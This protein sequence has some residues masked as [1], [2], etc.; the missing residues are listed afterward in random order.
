MQKRVRALSEGALMCALVGILL[1][2]NRQFGGII[3]YSFY[4]IMTFPILVYTVKY[5][6]KHG[7]MVTFSS[8]LLSMFLSTPT[9]IFYLVSCSL[10]GLVYG[11]GIRKQWP[12]AFL[13]TIT[14][15]ITLLSYII[16][17]GLLAALF[18]YQMTEE[19]TFFLQLFEQLS[20]PIGNA[21][22]FGVFLWGTI[23][24]LTAFLQTICVHV[25][26]ILLL[27]RLR[28]YEY[29]M[30]S[31]YDFRLPKVL[32]YACFIIWI[33]FLFGNVVKLEG[34][35]FTYLLCLWILVNIISIGYGVTTCFLWLMLHGKRRWSIVVVIGVFLPF[36]Q[37]LIAG[38]GMLDMCLD[39]RGKWKRGVL[40]GAF[41]KF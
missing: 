17:M 36:V 27:K 40:N 15:I 11:G 28:L 33:L 7:L 34:D 31:L 35:L 18:G 24:C 6:V 30:K 37:P 3:E 21:Q 38:I 10:L 13:L 32:G 25:V 39:M 22:I 41:R 9:M 19:I 23:L 16:T 29:R 2:F 20:F 8:L 26:S 4:W 14:G 5:G 1:F 12:N